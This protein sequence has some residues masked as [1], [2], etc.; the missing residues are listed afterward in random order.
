MLIDAA[1][2]SGCRY[3]RACSDL[4][5]DPRTVSSWKDSTIDQRSLNN[6]APKNKLTETERKK[7]IGICTSKR[8]VDLP[9]SKIV[10]ML[11]DEGEYIGSES[12]FYR[13]L[14]EEKLLSHRGRTKPKAK[15]KPRALKATAPNQIY[16]WDITYLKTNIKGQHFYLY[17]FMDVYSRKVVG[18]KVYE[19]ESMELSAKLIEE[20][21]IE[22]S[23]KKDQLT[24]HSDNGA[25]MKGSTML[26]KLQSLG[27][28]PSFSRPSVSDDNPYS[29]SLF[30]TLKYCPLYPKKPF[31]SLEEACR[32]VLNFKDWYN[33]EHLHSGIKFVTPEQRHKGEDKVILQKRKKVY[34]KAKEKNPIRWS[35]KIR[36]WDHDNVVH[37]NPLRKKKNDET[38]AA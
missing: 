36:N 29:E 37:L 3:T 28:M 10:P 15:R 16:S 23:I 31:E 13:I 33:K 17:M 14:K 22:N 26:S 5:L 2:Q 6:K 8:Y 11:A 24:L 27:V 18:S 38:Y 35:G 4:S 1:V 30:K 19:S 25:P 32:W 21:C 7:I 20:V 34:E 9:P 12:S